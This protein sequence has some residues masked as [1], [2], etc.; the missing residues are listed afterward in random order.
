MRKVRAS[1][2]K[3]EGRKSPYRVR[4]KPRNSEKDLTEWKETKKEANQRKKEIEEYENGN[5]DL[6]QELG[7]QEIREAQIKLKHTQNDRAKGKSILYAVDWFLENFQGGDEILE[8]KAYFKEYQKIKSALVTKHTLNSDQQLI[9]TKGTYA[10]INLH[11]EKKPTECSRKFLQKYIDEHE[12]KFHRH[13]ALRAFFNWMSGESSKY[14]NDNPCLVIDPMKKVILPKK[15]SDLPTEVAT[16]QEFADLLNLTHSKEYNYTAA[17]WAFMFFTG[18][19]PSECE[20]FWSSKDYG[21]NHVDFNDHPHIKVPKKFTRKRGQKERMIPIRSGF[22]NMLKTFKSEGESKYPLINVKDWKRKYANARKEIWGKRMIISTK[23]DDAK[24]ITRHTFITN[25]HLYSGSI[26]EATKESGTSEQTLTDHY[27]NTT[28]KITK[29]SAKYFFEEIDLSTFEKKIEVPK[30]DESQ[31]GETI[32]E[33][34]DRYS[35][36]TVIGSLS[37]EYGDSFSKS[38]TRGLVEAKIQKELQKYREKR[39]KDKD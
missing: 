17:R 9:G 29:T 19:R 2:C 16:N 28:C 36:E 21:W 30:I 5:S 4:Y 12:S 24:D 39:E 6:S 14:Y 25:L 26:A 8:L 33:L 10:F 7:F 3:F 31:I 1:I 15:Y 34:S 32:K 11:G 13:K 38:I 35:E 20:R 18:M 37:T 27:I 23:R 22:L